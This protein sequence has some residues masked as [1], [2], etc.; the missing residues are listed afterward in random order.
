MDLS[1]RHFLGAA[2]ALTGSALLAG[3][4]GFSTAG[5][6]SDSTGSDTLSFTTWGTDSE[7]AGFRKAI[8][9]FQ[10]ANPGTTVNLNAVPYEQMFTN[11]DAQ[12]QAGNPPDVFRVP[13]Y[14][15]GGY[16]GRGQLLDLSAHLDDDFGDRFTPTAWRA[17]QNQTE[18]N[19]S[20]PF[21]VPHHTDTSAILYNKALLSAAGVHSVPT[22][23]DQ[24]WTWSEFTK[25]ASTLRTSLPRGKYPFAYNWQGNGVTR[26]LSLL[27]QAGGRFLGP[28]LTHPAID[29]AAGRAAVDFS[30]NFFAAEF[31]PPNDSVKSTTY[32]ADMWYSQTTA[33]VFGGAFMIPDATSTLDFEWG[34]TFAP[35]KARGGGD[36]GGNAL[37]VTAGTKQ[38]ELAA[39]FLDYLTQPDQMRDFCAAASLLPTRRDLV[40]SGIE[41]AV[42]PELSP[43]FIGQASTVQPQDAG[44]VA[45]PSMTKIITVLKDQLEQAFVGGQSTEDT[46]TGLSAGIA[47][48]TK[49]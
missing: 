4:G 30:K 45:S 12:L 24:A 9:S 1:R 47:T 40:E 15:F 33:M 31:V 25:L 41:F 26:W 28:D 29:S 38:P 10:Q 44:Q 14:T 13:Y 19:T 2:S 11:I 42:R 16:A 21:G 37:V 17:V 39:K 8:A 46:I 27:F 23:V 22:S 7:L 49:Q 20:V 32:A 18:Q 48:A 35:R 43:V 5:T 34:A 3:C 36:F 6:G